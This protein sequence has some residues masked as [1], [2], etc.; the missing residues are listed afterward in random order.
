MKWF[1]CQNGCLMVAGYRLE[2]SGVMAGGGGA[3]GHSLA[4]ALTLPVTPPVRLPVC[5]CESE[6]G[7]R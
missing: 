2:A 4:P 1:S 3:A 6:M 5:V 7:D